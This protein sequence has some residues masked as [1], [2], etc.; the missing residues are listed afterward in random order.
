MSMGTV[1]KQA[2]LLQTLV[3]A[4]VL[5]PVNPD[6]VTAPAQG[7]LP[8]CWEISLLRSSLSH[9]AMLSCFEKSS[10]NLATLKARTV[11]GNGSQ[12]TQD[13]QQTLE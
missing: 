13:S 6:C 5:E 9:E 12:Q 3:V 11:F 8:F 7:L 10:C 1:P 2:A 4:A